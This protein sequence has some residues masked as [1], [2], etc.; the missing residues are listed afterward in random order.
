[1]GRAQLSSQSELFAQ[2]AG[3]YSSGQLS[4]LLASESL[5]SSSSSAPD[6]RRESARK[7]RLEKRLPEHFF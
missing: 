4:Y 5:P 1:M 6:S 2:P 3:Y 7:S